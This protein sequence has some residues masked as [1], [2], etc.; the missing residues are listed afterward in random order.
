[1]KKLVLYVGAVVVGLVFL[2]RPEPLLK[3]VETSVPGPVVF[4][5]SGATVESLQG[6][7]DEFRAALGGQDNGDSTGPISTGRREINWNGSGSSR[8][9]R[10]TPSDPD[11]GTVTL[12]EFFVPG[13]GELPATTT[14]F[15]V[16]VSNVDR[17]EG[18]LISV[19][20]VQ[21]DL[22]YT[23]TVPGS[24]DVAGLTFL[25]VVFPDARIASVRI[26]SGNDVVF[27]EPQPIF[28]SQ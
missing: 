18:A 20:G 25:G 1:M 26:S 9:V 24:P 23:K 13:G 19:Y 5:I 8:G 4:Q 28:D 16:I 7:I 17:A 10:F 3:A 14:G 15:G 21:G 2:G 12:V 27:G 6:V 22:L 11:S